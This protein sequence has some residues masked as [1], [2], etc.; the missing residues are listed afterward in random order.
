MQ[1]EE[2]GAGAWPFGVDECSEAGRVNR[3]Q[4]NFRGLR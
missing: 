2:R 3:S 1:R 4:E